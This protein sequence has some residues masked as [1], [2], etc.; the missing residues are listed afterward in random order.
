[1]K[2][3]ICSLAMAVLN[4]TVV[5]R[6]AAAELQFGNPELLLRFQDAAGGFGLLEMTNKRDGGSFV[7]QNP[8]HAAL[9]LVRLSRA[10]RVDDQTASFYTDTGVLVT[11]RVNPLA[12]MVSIDSNAP[13]RRSFRRYHREDGAA[14]LE[15]IWDD[16]AVDGEKSALKAVAS[17]ET[18]PA[19]GSVLGRLRVEVKSRKYALESSA[20]PHI[21]PMSEAGTYHLLLPR[22]TYGGQF[23]RNNKQDFSL[24]YPSIIAQESCMAMLRP[25]A[26]GIYWAFHD[27][28]AA[29]KGITVG[30]ALSATVEAAAANSGVTGRSRAIDY[31]WE[32]S[33]IR[34]EWG[35]AELYLNRAQ[36]QPWLQKGPLRDRTDLPE[37]YRDIELWVNISGSPAEMKAA[38]DRVREEVGDA[39]VAVHWYNWNIYPFDTNYPE[40]FPALEGSEKVIR[41]ITANGD[42]VVPYINGHCWDPQLPSYRT[43]G[44]RAAVK[45]R[46]GEIAL[47]KYGPV[48]LLAPVCPTSPEFQRR[49]Q[50]TCRKLV[51]M[52]VN[53]IYLDQVGQLSPMSC[54]DATHG[55]ELGNG[56]YWTGGYRSMLGKI[57]EEHAG[58]IFLATE[59]AAEPYIDTISS[60]LVWTEITGDDF[61]LLPQIYNRY[62]FYYG[63]LSFP[64][65][66]MQSFAAAQKRCLPWGYQ[67]G[68]MGW[69]HG[70]APDKR[71]PGH[72]EKIAYLNQVI[73]LR[74]EIKAC[75]LDGAL[76]HDVKILSENPAVR[77]KWFRMNGE[78]H[79][80]PV[81]SGAVWRNEKR[82][83]AV[84]VLANLDTRERIGSIEIDPQLYGLKVMPSV[85]RQLR[86]NLHG[87]LNKNGKSVIEVPVPALGFALL[88]LSAK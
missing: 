3:I 10:G 51:A 66:S 77:I 76:V 11:E 53:G 45:K 12:G 48:N 33:P 36:H 85:Y 41:E 52:G 68:W 58:K 72:A 73:A 6:P 5:V 62:A 61:P 60:F 56:D 79:D 78:E 74:R 19:G 26:G 2:K 23:F 30:A 80:E 37:H 17:F 87:A 28:G 27:A 69:L 67:P 4:M 44:I 59:N 34:D 46:S 42:F 22:L 70:Q 83:G 8:A 82:D 35:A 16:I 32:I 47:E 81:L 43:E 65:D 15:L 71:S 20:F 9:W 24:L 55:H 21:G 18:G 7:S 39:R 29:A 54:F 50:E 38:Y 49:I 75:L 88:E 1:M 57:M 13:A 31:C 86:G 84:V 64:E 14:V 25:D 40:Y 63:A